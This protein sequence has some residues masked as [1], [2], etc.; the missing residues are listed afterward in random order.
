M[1]TIIL[2]GTN[3]SLYIFEDNVVVD[4]AADKTTIGNPATEYILDCNTSNVTLYENVTP[5]EDWV[6]WKYLFDG[7][8]WALNPGYN[9]PTPPQE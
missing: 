6:G 7:T 8:E 9:P 2:Q 4:I 5:P 1:K 3:V